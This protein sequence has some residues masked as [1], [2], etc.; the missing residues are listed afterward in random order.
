MKF[1]NKCTSIGISLLLTTSVYAIEIKV[2]IISDYANQHEYKLSLLKLVLNKAGVEAD[3]K[4]KSSKMTQ[5]R[6]VEQLKEGKRVN[7]FWMGTSEG[8]EKDLLPIRFPMYRGLLGHRAFVI[9]KDNQA[10]FDKVN[11]L[12]DLQ[13]YKG[14]QGVGWSDVVVLE[15][16]GLKQYQTTYEKLFKMINAEGRLDYFSR[17]VTEAFREVENRQDK[18]KNLTV[19]KKLLLV[20][21][22]AMYFFTSKSNTELATALEEGFRKAYEDGSFEEFFYSHPEIK[23]IFKQA[24]L[25]NRLRIDIPN[26]LLTSETAGLPDKYWH[27]R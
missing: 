11:N 12:A 8:L 1:I 24:N 15:N 16:S 17:G 3:I 2:P 19:E 26:P 6:I 13:K 14:G 27:G 9:H 22:F 25:D 4:F 20:Y 21:P 23:K 5:G 18:L 7:L 10:I